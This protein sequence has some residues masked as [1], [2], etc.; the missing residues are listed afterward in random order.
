[1]EFQFEQMRPTGNNEIGI[2]GGSKK[3]YFYYKKTKRKLNIFFAS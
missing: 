1:M 2:S 3:V